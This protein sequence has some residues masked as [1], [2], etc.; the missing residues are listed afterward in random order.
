[1]AEMQEKVLGEIR[2]IVEEDH[3]P[4]EYVAQPR[5]ANMGTVY[6]QDGF[7]TV[8]EVG[9]YFQ[10]RDCTMTLA[11]PAVARALP[12]TGDGSAGYRIHGPAATGR[13]GNSVHFH[14]LQYSDGPR[15]KVLFGLIRHCC[16]A[17]LAEASR[18]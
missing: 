12:E 6:V 14:A 15:L 5:F 8:F 13:P 7:D 16:A 18:G 11:G 3:K 4:L 17:A 9:Y 2:R 1:M 10:G